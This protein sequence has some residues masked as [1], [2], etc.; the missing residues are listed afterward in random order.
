MWAKV[1]NDI[2]ALRDMEFF[3]IEDRDWVLMC[4]MFDGVRVDG[5]ASFITW[6]LG[7]KKSWNNRGHHIF[8][9]SEYGKTWRCWYSEPETTLMK[10]TKW[11]E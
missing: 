11:K 10:N 6:P 5:A 8:K 4:A 2:G 3:Y 7:K 1:I 9:I